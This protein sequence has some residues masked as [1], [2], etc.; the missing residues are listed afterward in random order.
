MRDATLE[1]V[2]DTTKE[3]S[4]V[5]VEIWSDIACPWCY[6]GKRRF[7]A[8]LARFDHRDAVRVIWRSFELDPSAPREREG[9][10]V[11]RMAEKYGMALEQAQA[12]Q[13][14]LTDL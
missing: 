11:A 12:A 13:Q 14:R 3:C 10:R 5:D 8:A 6:V 1:L 2:A 7:E 9:D 4:L